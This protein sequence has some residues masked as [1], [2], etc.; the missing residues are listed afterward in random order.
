MKIN[1]KTFLKEEPE[2]NGQFER[3]RYIWEDI[4]INFQAILRHGMGFIH[5]A[6]DRDQ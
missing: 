6:R 4:K 3:L 2:G 1:A 5:V